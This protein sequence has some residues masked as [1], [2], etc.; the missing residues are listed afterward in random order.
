MKV[1]ASKD[2]Y[3]LLHKKELEILISD[4]TMAARKTAKLKEEVAKGIIQFWAD[5][6]IKIS[7]MELSDWALQEPIDD[8]E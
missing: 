2:G 3:W 8:P 4:L 1:Y 6:E 7:E 5:N